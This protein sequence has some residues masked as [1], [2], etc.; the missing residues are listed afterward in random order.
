MKKYNI[1]S[2]L[3]VVSEWISEHNKRNI[4]K[5]ALAS[6]FVG[7]FEVI[8]LLSIK[9]IL[10]IFNDKNNIEFSLFGSNPNNLLLIIAL[11]Y[12]LML[13]LIAFLR[14][15]TIS[16]GNFLSANIGLEIGNNLLKNFLGQDF[17]KH[18]NRDSAI[19]INT[20]SL[21]LTRT[22]RFI[23][24]FLQ[25]LVAFS[26]TICILI[27]IVFENPISVTGTFLSVVL[28]YVFIAKRLKIRTLNYA[29]K[30]KIS[31]DEIT[32]L[33]QEVTSDIEKNLIEYRDNEIIRKFSNSYK[34]NRLSDAK[35]RDYSTIPRYVIEVAAITSFLMLTIISALFF[36]QD[37]ITLIAK[38][39]ASLLGLQKLLPSINTIYSSWNIMNN[40]MPN[41]YSVKDLISK[42]SYKSRIDDANKKI[43]YFKN[44]I[45]ISKITFGYE[46]NKHIFN[47]FSLR[48]KK[49]EKIL[50][51]GKS[52]F[53][54]STL[55][56]IICCLIKPSIGEILID[57]KSLNS[58]K[59]ISNWQRQIGLVKQ[60]PYLKRG[61]I[62]DLILG[63]EISGDFNK[64]LKEAKKFAKLACI[65]NFIETLP[66][67]YLEN[68][69]QDGDSLSGGQIQRISI[70][71]TLALKPSLLILDESTTGIDIET[72]SK[73]LENIIKLE[74]LTTIVVS[75]SKN[76]ESFF[77]E[78]L[79]L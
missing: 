27:F 37:N 79:I 18:L 42:Y 15:K 74:N 39:S 48:I 52:G 76:V 34:E 72:E 58:Q 69:N 29:N 3:I 7:L 61:K 2:T 30:A 11:S 66:N 4:I 5:L 26:C 36:K 49:G 22:S 73:I 35:M 53:G 44:S 28:G 57:D 68:I 12:T 8:S 24:L 21:H 38:L 45:V 64:D 33:T 54:K 50:I 13:C 71:S 78:K 9:P 10:T 32:K 25:V 41:V 55:I 65:D 60:K 56:K 51:R 62:I 14:I 23:N 6:I 43:N 75:H 67:G 40:S 16:Y 17:L 63:K 77:T 46:K 31:L 19:V 1:I 59:S 70:A 47:N 20:F